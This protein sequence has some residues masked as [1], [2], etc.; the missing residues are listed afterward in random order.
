MKQAVIAIDGPAAS[1]KS[2]V[3][4]AVAK[5]IGAVYADSGALYRLVTWWL[6]GMGIDPEDDQSVRAALGE[7]KVTAAVVD[8]RIS[9]STGADCPPDALRTQRVNLAVSPVAANPDVRNV[10]TAVLQSLLRFG[11]LVMEGRDI[12]TV[13][14]PEAAYK[15]YLD[16][17]PEVRAR[18]RFTDKDGNVDKIGLDDVLKSLARRDKID[19]SRKAAPLRTADD[20]I[21]IDTSDLDINGV[22]EQI[23]SFLS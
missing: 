2:T 23:C 21:V 14:F 20:A 9:Y 10:V 1:G 3:A 13:V 4:K 7:L 16:A 22:V 15:F 5:R 11:M 6:L 8:G 17:S 12:G 19:S 18:R